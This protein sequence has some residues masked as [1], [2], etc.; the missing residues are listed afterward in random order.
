MLVIVYAVHASDFP[1]TGPGQFAEVRKI[2]PLLVAPTEAK[3]PAF[4]VVA[5]SLPGFGF[6]SA[7]KK[8]GFAGD[9]YAEVNLFYRARSGTD[10]DE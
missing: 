4:H 5:P 3:A 9:Q 10:V 2:L 1:S 6:T 8:K 7:P